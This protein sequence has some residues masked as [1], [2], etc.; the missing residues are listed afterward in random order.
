MAESTP[1]G[2]QV[3][4]KLFIEQYPDL[5]TPGFI[6]SI[7]F[8]F[9]PRDFMFPHESRFTS[10]FQR[11]LSVKARMYALL[12]SKKE[13]VVKGDCLFSVSHTCDHDPRA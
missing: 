7:T 12:P 6:T 10:S 2:K 3:T 11:F 5:A 13:N 1:G 8:D 4:R 9:A